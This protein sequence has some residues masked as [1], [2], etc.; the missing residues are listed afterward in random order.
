MDMQWAPVRLLHVF[1]ADV[2]GA[3]VPVVVRV[4]GLV[5]HEP[6]EQ[7]AEV[8]EHA[9]LVLVH[10]DAARRVRRIDRADAVLDAGLANDLRDIVGDVGE[11]PA[12][13]VV[14]APFGLE[15]LHRLASVTGRRRF[16]LRPAGRGTLGGRGP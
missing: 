12:P 16:A 14:N 2:L 3:V 10:P 15:H 4:V 11:M 13:V 5:R 6:A 9:A 8:L 1:L 7:R